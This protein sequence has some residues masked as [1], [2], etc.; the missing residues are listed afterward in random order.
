MCGSGRLLAEEAN[1]KFMSQLEKYEYYLD[2]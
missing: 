1:I 2:I